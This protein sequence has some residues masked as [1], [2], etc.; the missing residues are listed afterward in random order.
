MATKSK[1]SSR[2]VKRL[3]EPGNNVVCA[4]CH[5]IVKFM[6]REQTHQIIANVYTNGKWD[7]VEHW[8]E[9]C[10]EEDSEPY[11]QPAA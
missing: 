10:Y 9:K 3:I 5:E 6:T 4:K 1:L 7:R 8:H 11:G 2:A